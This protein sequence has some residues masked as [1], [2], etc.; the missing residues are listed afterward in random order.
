[1][2]KL[3]YFIVPLLIV[4]A[5]AS[6]L[7]SRET[8]QNAQLS[9]LSGLHRISNHLT[10]IS[11]ESPEDLNFC[12]ERVP[13][14]NFDVKERMDL[15]LQKNVYYHSSTV[16][17]LKRRGRYYETFTRILKEQGIPEDMFFLSV[18]ESGLSNAVS[19]VGAKGFW[20]FMPATAKHYGLELSGT[21]DERFHPEKA[22][23]AA[24]EY[25]KDAYRRFG[26][27]TLVAAAYN[28]GPGG[29]SRAM[30]TQEADSYYD[31]H[32][33]KETSAYV[34]RILAFK[35]IMSTPYRYGFN[36]SD[37]YEPIPYREV[38]VTGNIANLAAYARQNGSNY[39]M[40]KLLNPWLISDNLVGEKG[41]TYSI[42]FP[43]NPESV[44][45]YEMEIVDRRSKEEE[46]K[47]VE[48]EIS[49]EADSLESVESADSVSQIAAPAQTKDA[50]RDTVKK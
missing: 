21:V 24:T 46:V 18:A 16:L 19:P 38:E 48:T 41:K 33:N 43:L 5:G 17:L 42:R 50:A 3:S 13:L 37:T 22:T 30:R 9:Q 44:R 28:M 2:S 26:D 29:V 36:V 39:R 8:P 27:W 10:V 31:L 32:L 25:L 40:L 1:M 14:E 34:F 49:V 11:A 12:E 20:Q 15:E 6:I 47:E 7:S 35:T 45:A 23:Y 4:I